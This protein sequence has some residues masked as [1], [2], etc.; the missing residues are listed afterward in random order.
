NC[1]LRHAGANGGRDVLRFAQIAK[2]DW[3]ELAN[4]GEVKE[5]GVGV[6]RKCKSGYTRAKMRQHCRHPRALGT[7]MAGEQNAF[8]PP[9]RWIER[10]AHQA[11]VFH[12]AAPLGHRS[13]SAFLSRSVSI[14]CQNPV[15][16]KAMS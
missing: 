6:G 9:E 4:L 1:N 5:T 10:Y 13:S 15:W 12:G 11:Q 7:G 16:R 14:G 8:A 2:A 3:H